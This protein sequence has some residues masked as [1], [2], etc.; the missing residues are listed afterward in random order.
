MGYADPCNHVTGRQ[1]LQLTMLVSEEQATSKHSDCT[2][3]KYLHV[4]WAQQDR[5]A[6]AQMLLV[7]PVYEMTWMGGLPVYKAA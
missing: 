7:L 3:L 2:G 1:P 4:A 6:R 5:S